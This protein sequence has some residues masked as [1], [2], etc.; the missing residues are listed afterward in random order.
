MRERI[1]DPFVQLESE[2]RRPTRTG[3]GLGL[4]FCKLA[5][6]AH[7]GQIWI[8]DANPGAIFVV[9]IPDAS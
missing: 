4:T 7:G 2:E 1:F 5:V 9:R 3:R 8:E 6:E